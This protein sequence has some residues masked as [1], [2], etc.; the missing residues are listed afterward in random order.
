LEAP[1]APARQGEEEVLSD[2]HL[3][4]VALGKRIALADEPRGQRLEY[5]I[6]GANHAGAGVP[7]NTVT[8]IL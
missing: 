2:W 4:T 8:V 1:R 6:R 7:S 5:R 3:A